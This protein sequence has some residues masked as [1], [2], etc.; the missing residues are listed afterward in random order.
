MKYSSCT[1]TL[2]L[3]DMNEMTFFSAVAWQE[4]KKLCTTGEWSKKTELC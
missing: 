2:K 3:M 1:G 4:L